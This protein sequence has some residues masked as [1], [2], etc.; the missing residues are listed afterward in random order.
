[1]TDFDE[2]SALRDLLKKT[3]DTQERL[4]RVALA[5]LMFHR[6]GPWTVEDRAEWT[7]L[8]GEVE[9]TTR[10]LCDFTKE[11]LRAVAP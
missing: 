10:A 11:Q 1:M 7:K 3:Q 9:C 2:I 8:T 4:G 5:V 6:G